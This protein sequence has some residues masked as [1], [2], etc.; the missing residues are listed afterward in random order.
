MQPSGANTNSRVWI[1]DVGRRTFTPLTTAGEAALWS[2]W[3]PGGTRIVFNVDVAGKMNLFW[4]S[5]DG[6]GTSER[7]T[8]SEYHHGP[9][10]WAP[11]DKTLAFV[12]QPHSAIGSDIRVLDVAS[13]DRRAGSVM[14]TPAEERF[15]AFSADG[16]WLAYTSTESGRVEVYVQPYPGPG[17]RVL[18]STDGGTGPA[19]SADGTELFYY[20]ALPQNL[21]HMMVVA[22]KASA[23]GFSAGTPRKLFEGRYTMS[24]PVRGYDVTPDG[25]RFLMVRPLDPPPE[26]ASEL[27]L[28]ENW[29]EEVKGR[30][31][32]R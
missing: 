6:S 9:N 4:K 5:A 12:E 8:T 15:P 2:V 13:T 27:V 23:A 18:V 10:S 11:D 32:A 31:A 16:R 19:W 3:S 22:V 7:L 20:A 29:L 1:Y 26:P 25:R 24:D 28:V 17:P 30:A 21:V 14:Q